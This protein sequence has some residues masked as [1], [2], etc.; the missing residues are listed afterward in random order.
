MALYKIRMRDREYL[1]SYQ[2][3]CTAISICI[4]QQLYGPII[5][6]LV[7]NCMVVLYTHM[8]EFISAFE[9]LRSKGKLYVL[10][11]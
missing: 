8:Y 2:K 9:C 3:L 6:V 5:T 10:C 7:T 1:Q 11:I 4:T